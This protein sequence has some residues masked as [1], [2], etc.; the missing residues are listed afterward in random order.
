MSC[1]PNP[2]SAHKYGLHVDPSKCILYLLAGGP[3]SGGCFTFPSLRPQSC[4]WRGCYDVESP[5]R[6]QSGFSARLSSPETSGVW[7]PLYHVGNIASCSCCLLPVS[8]WGVLCRNCSG[9]AVPPH[10]PTSLHC[11]KI[12]TTARNEPWKHFWE[13]LWVTINGPRPSSS[14]SSWWKASNTSS[15]LPR[16]KASS[17]NAG[18]KSGGGLELSLR[19]SSTIR[20]R[21]RQKSSPIMGPTLLSPTTTFN[22]PL[23]N[24]I[25]GAPI[26]IGRELCGRRGVLL[27][28]LEKFLG[29]Q[30]IES[31]PDVFCR[32]DVIV[33]LSILVTWLRPTGNPNHKLS[34]QKSV[35]NTLLIQS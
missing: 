26:T 33:S 15:T 11:C 4:H 18:S 25:G 20:C 22:R 19:A 35:P 1:S 12:S 21:V 6:R 7:F 3:V 28:I 29:K 5:H 13:A 2:I 9:G 34:W 14:W 17:A 31:I 32:K 16:E 24:Q 10:G 8:L 23:V 27:G 30:F